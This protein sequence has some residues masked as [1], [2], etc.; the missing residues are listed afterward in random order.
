MRKPSQSLQKTGVI[1]NKK[2]KKRKQ[3]R[4]SS[5]LD[6]QSL[7]HV[8][9][10]PPQNELIS[11]PVASDFV[12]EIFLDR[13]VKEVVKPFQ[14]NKNKKRDYR[15]GS[16]TTTP[17]NGS[18]TGSY[19]VMIGGKLVKK[20]KTS[21]D[22]Q[23]ET[24]F[25]TEHSRAGNEI[26][27]SLLRKR[28]FWKE[29]IVVGSNQCLR[30]LET[31]IANRHNK[32]HTTTNQNS[33]GISNCKKND[34][35]ARPQPSLI[36]L[37]KDIYPPTMCSAIPALARNLGIPLLLL[38][39]KASLELGKVMNAKRTSVLIFLP[40]GNDSNDSGAKIT[41]CDGNAEKESREAQTAIASFVSFIKDQMS[42][43]S[44]NDAA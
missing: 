34:T 33:G 18:N 41:D 14:P 31:A 17:N 3:Y 26:D 42:A 35:V 22:N 19:H 9:G 16:K 2:T 15:E 32:E 29:N 28:R 30:V 36:V 24:A 11:T 38:P 21:K 40:G 5:F 4:P 44:G 39:G 27:A 23:S 10:F 25:R 6:C 12:K 37:A 7:T 8:V 43:R 1:K 13:F 20:R